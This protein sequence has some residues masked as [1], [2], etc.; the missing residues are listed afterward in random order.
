MKTMILMGISCLLLAGVY[1]VM[2]KESVVSKTL[3]FNYANG[4]VSP[5]DAED[6]DNKIDGLPT[7]SSEH[8]TSASTTLDDSH[9]I[10]DPLFEK[11]AESG[12]ITD[13]EIDLSTG[14]KADPETI[15]TAPQG[16]EEKVTA[17]APE[18][19]QLILELE[20]DSGTGKVPVETI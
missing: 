20:P 12:L 4:A 16:E 13:S 9:W 18:I 6:R 3:S 14:P 19:K 2:N 1:G 17:P 15:K 7:D 11:A 8:K 10:Y 5:I